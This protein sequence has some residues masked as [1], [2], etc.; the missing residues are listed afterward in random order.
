MRDS[1]VW[2]VLTALACAVDDRSVDVASE[3]STAAND[4]A[5]A[6]TI[7]STP[8]GGNQPD[9]LGSAGSGAMPAGGTG[10]MM[11]M[12]A[13]S[14]C[15][16]VRDAVASPVDLLLQLDSSASMLEVV[17]MA[18]AP[19][20]VGTKWDAV[21]QGLGAFVQAAETAQTGIGLSYFPQ[22]VAGVPSS[23]TSNADC[24]SAGPCTSSI[25][26]ESVTQTSGVASLTFLNA[27]ADDTAPC[28]SDAECESGATCR[29]ISGVCVANG[30]V[31]ALGLDATGAASIPRCSSQGDCAGLPG[32]TCEEVGIC[33]D[34]F[35]TCTPSIGC[36][37]G[38]AC[39]PLP[40]NCLHQ[41]RCEVA[42]Y[43]TPAVPIRAASLGAA[44]IVDSLAAR[45]PNG[46]TPT[47]PA[48]SGALGYAQLW[49]QQHPERR[50]A[51]VLATDGFP[52]ECTP[53]EI[54]PIAQL[55]AAAAGRAQPLQTFVIGV[56]SV[57]DLGQD[58]QAR[59]DEL[60]AAG[61]TGHAWLADTAG[62]VARS[63]E[64]ALRAIRANAASCGLSLDADVVPAADTVQVE[65][66]GADGSIRALPRL[67]GPG[68]C[69]E[70]AGWYFV[71]DGIGVPARIELCPTVCPAPGGSTRARLRLGC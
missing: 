36:A 53:I 7:G 60:A 29:A 14:S 4:G 17:S 35:T 26:V 65:L 58:G 50:V 13:D 30:S 10:E 46:L 70:G 23:C 66:V 47:G 9:A 51:A 3:R 63:F 64:N 1:S 41:T 38:A 21:R 34:V 56:F 43:S 71:R 49:A 22:L 40:Y 31:P 6:D 24:G 20:T 5:V 39:T 28:A 18:G 69:A 33:P 54:A 68:G 55:A 57:R 25:C 8:S 19:G 42:D 15:G 52:T 59:L 61:S 62:D 48:L 44:T 27:S 67:T 2:L 37:G 12:P 16:E 32:T 45:V 11:S